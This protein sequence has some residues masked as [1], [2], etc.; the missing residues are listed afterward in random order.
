MG[1]SNGSSPAVLT[2]KQTT[3]NKQQSHLF[4]KFASQQHGRRGRGGQNVTESL[5]VEAPELAGGRSYD[6]GC[7]GRVVEKGKFAK[8]AACLVGRCLHAV[9]IG[10]AAPS[11]E[12]VKQVSLV[13][14]ANH[15]LPV[16]GKGGLH[17]VNNAVQILTAQGLE[18]VMVGQGISKEES[19]RLGLGVRRDS[20]DLVRVEVVGVVVDLSAAKIGCGWGWCASR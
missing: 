9:D 20:L 11:L 13:P 3:N 1:P 18:K 14:L 5:E 19:R 8:A 15:R 17:C 10:R 12:A 2:G 16:F 7:S 4:E 6:A